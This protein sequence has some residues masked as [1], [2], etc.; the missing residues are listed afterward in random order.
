MSLIYVSEFADIAQM[1]QGDSTEMFASPAIT[2]YTVIVSAASSG[3]PILRP[4]TKFVEL[5]CDTTC[6]F[7][8][9]IA[10]TGSCGL[11]D[12][13]LNANERIRRRVPFNMQAIGPGVNPVASTQY[14]IFSTANV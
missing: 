7:R 10:A 8:I 2:S 12:T 1:S 11:T 9:D 5:S 4:T 6:S 14:A 13:R 3:G